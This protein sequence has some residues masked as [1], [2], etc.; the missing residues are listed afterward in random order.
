MVKPT[1]LKLTFKS[2]VENANTR[3]A[4]LQVKQR[5]CPNAATNAKTKEERKPLSFK[6][7]S[8]RVYKKSCSRPVV[9]QV[10]YEIQWI[11]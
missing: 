11:L 1:R 3:M 4:Q 10:V 2:G 6:A 7:L 5:T 9:I 8:T